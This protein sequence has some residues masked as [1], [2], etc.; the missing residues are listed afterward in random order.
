[1]KGLFLYGAKC[2]PEVWARLRPHLTGIEATFAEYPAEALRRARST[3]DLAEW[4]CDAFADRTYDFLLG[5]SMG[6]YV[7][8]QMAGRGFPAPRLLLVESNPVPS[9][10]FY[11]NLMTP[12]HM[13]R[14]GDA[15]SAMFRRR[16]TPYSGALLSALRDGFDFSDAA[17]RL[18]REIRAIYGD[19]NRPDDPARDADLHLPAP[20]WQKLRPSFVPDACHMPMLENPPALAAAIRAALAGEASA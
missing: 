3:A 4:A 11:R 17:L 18:P 14:F 12:E 8:L 2:G 1:M 15:V 19:R 13:A 6:G 10:P 20:L 5:H 16:E 9:G 7:A